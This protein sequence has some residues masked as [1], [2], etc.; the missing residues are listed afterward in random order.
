MAYKTWQED[1][2][3]V[4]SYKGLAG[5]L[6]EALVKHLHVIQGAETVWDD[7]QISG[8]ALSAAA[9][10][11][12]F[13]AIGGGTLQARGFTGTSGMN[14]LF[15][16]IELEH[17]YV[18]GTDIWP[19]IHWMPENNT[20]ANVKWNLT[21]AIAVGGVVLTAETI[22]SKTV[23]TSGTAWM[24][25][26]T[27]WDTPISGTGRKIGDQIFFR[28]WRDSADA[29]DTYGAVAFVSTFGLHVQENS[30]GSAA[31]FTK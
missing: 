22:L 10:A 30:V 11:P 12:G 8:S 13:A 9:S 25:H 17:G 23:A 31:R 7:Q 3:P 26:N 1:L 5:R 24:L 29:A 19:H 14:Q 6:W 15:G 27:E 20:V 16:A 21:Y 2:S 18:E 28:L 4:G